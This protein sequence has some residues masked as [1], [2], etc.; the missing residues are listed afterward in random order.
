MVPRPGQPES[1][2]Q[3]HHSSVSTPTW[4]RMA[5]LP[6]LLDK[7]NIKHFLDS[8]DT[9]L[10]D[11]DGVLWNGDYII[12]QANDALNQLR[13]LGKKVFFITNNS[14]KSRDTYLA[15][16]E[17]LDIIGS[18]EEIV[19]SSYVMAQYLKQ[20]N[21]N[22]KV[23]VVGNKGMSD[24]LDNVGIAHMGVEPDPLVG[25]VF[26][27]KDIKD[28]VELDP[29]VGAVAVGFDG[30]FSFPK[31]LRAASY[32]NKPGCL[33]IAT[34]TDE[35]FPIQSSK[36]IFPGTGCMVR[37]VETVAMRPPTIMGKPSK[38]MFSVISEQHQLQPSRTIVIGDNCKTDIV[39]GKNCGLHTMMVL[40]GITQMKEL[41][42]YAA[43]QDEEKH[44]RLPDYYLP[45]LEDLIP[46]L[47][48]ENCK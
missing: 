39:F 20:Q 33:F 41:E 47:N 11:C 22:K 23:Y 17:R 10:T 43:N 9:V 3:T 31:I 1:R 40:S 18:K 28:V 46:L 12:G 38:M 5:A 44:K 6:K 16:F 24:E 32:L 27:L 34:N 45:Q 29:E 48:D 30:T 37:C 21:F 14:T 19:S 7:S 36:L 8:F 26:D 4:R 35:R 15:K 2:I 42:E 25:C 13:A